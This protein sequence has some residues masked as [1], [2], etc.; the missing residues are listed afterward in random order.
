MTERTRFPVLTVRDS[1]LE[2]W[3]GAE[4]SYNAASERPGYSVISWPHDRPP[5]APLSA[6]A[7]DD[8]Q[9]HL[10][11]AVASLEGRAVA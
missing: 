6:L 11:R 3:Y 1:E 2:E 7:C 8:E 10:S 5:V 4:W 9:V